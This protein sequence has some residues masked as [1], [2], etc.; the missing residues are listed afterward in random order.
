MSVMKGVARTLVAAS[1]CAGLV[2][3]GTSHA[4]QFRYALGFPPNS[5]GDDGAQLFNEKLQEYS[6]GALSFRIFPLSLLS[7]AEMSEGV[8]DGIADVGNVLT[9]YFPSQFPNTNMAVELSM[10]LALSDQAQGRLGMA[11]SGAISEYLMLACP[12]CQEEFAAQRQVILPL[13]AT[14]EYQLMCTQP[15]RTAEE[16]RGKRLRVAGAQ[17]SR[18]AEHFGASTVSMSANEILEALGQGVVDCT[19]QS[20]PEL[21]NFRLK[22]VVTDITVNIPGGVFAGGSASFNLGVWRGLDAEQRRHIL[23]A[24]ADMNAEVTWLYQTYGDRDFAEAKESGVNIHE[25]DESLVQASRAFVEQDLERIAEIYEQ[26]HGIA[27]AAE[28]IEVLQPLVERWMTL[29]EENP[30]ASSEE[31]A[32]LYWDEIY[33]RVDHET[34]GM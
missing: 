23:R 10:L 15:I 7:L 14:P 9:P 3:A 5:A 32:Q 8:R 30:P 1:L 29:L 28:K 4:Q 21:G 2:L 11:Y 22:E 20:S 27:D 17:W 16:L 26:R 12:D 24:A 31:L 6:D 33:N 13:G 18:W 25:P 19:V 34:Y